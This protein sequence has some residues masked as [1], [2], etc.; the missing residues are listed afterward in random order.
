MCAGQVETHDPEKGAAFASASVTIMV[1]VDKP[2]TLQCALT[3]TMT[4][5]E[6]VETVKAPAN[7]PVVFVFRKRLTSGRR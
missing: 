7:T 6:T 5:R 1:E 2:A 4:R 3:D